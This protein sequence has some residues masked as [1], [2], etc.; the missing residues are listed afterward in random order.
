MN[1]YTALQDG[2]AALNYDADINV[3]EKSR[4]ENE[5]LN[6][7]KPQIVIFPDWTAQTTLSQGYQ[8][9]KTINYNID[10]KTLDEWD[11]SDLNSLKSYAQSSI[12]II[13]S[14]TILADSLFAWIS[15][16]KVIYNLTDQLTWTSS[17]PLLRENGG[18][19]SGVRVRLVVK[20]TG[21]KL[22]P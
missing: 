13:E 16:Q 12:E 21:S 6:Y 1:I 14:M 11:N 4:D 17:A 2:L 9:L 22:C 19:M 20:E 18:T 8:I 3:F 7:T 5:T 15:L 10:F